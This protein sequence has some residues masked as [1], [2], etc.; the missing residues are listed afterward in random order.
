M[1]RIRKPADA[2][3]NVQ[4]QV[5]IDLDELEL[6]AKK[7]DAYYNEYEMVYK[8]KRLKEAISDFNS[9]F[10]ENY[11]KIEEAL[12]NYVIEVKEGKGDEE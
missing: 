3:F 2:D 12:E 1:E 5:Y 10:K 4:N 6:S 9:W 11:D 8:V 7:F